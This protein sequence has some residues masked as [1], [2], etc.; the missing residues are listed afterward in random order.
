[1]RARSW[2]WC[3]FFFRRLTLP[4]G[5]LHQVDVVVTYVTPTTWILT[6]KFQQHLVLTSYLLPKNEA[7]KYSKNSKKPR[8]DESDKRRNP[9]PN[10][11]PVV[12]SNKN[13]G[14]DKDKSANEDED[15]IE[16]MRG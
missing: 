3:F 14:H 2:C 10:S 7:Q 12:L 11:N 9:L 1:M 5:G 4:F 6:T 8:H 15:E 13:V 16:R